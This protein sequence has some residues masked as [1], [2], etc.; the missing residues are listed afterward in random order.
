M[1][2]PR[3]FKNL[4]HYPYPSL[5]VNKYHLQIFQNIQSRK[6][7]PNLLHQISNT[8]HRFHIEHKMSSLSQHP[9]LFSQ[10]LSDAFTDLGLK[11]P[12]DFDWKETEEAH[13]FK[14]DLPGFTREDV[15][16][17]V[18]DHKVLDISAERKSEI[19][20]NEKGEIK[21]HCKERTQ[22]GH[23]HR[24]FRLPDDALVDQISASMRD[25]VLVVMVA[26][27]KRKEK[28]KEKSKVVDIDDRENGSHAKGLGRF[29]C[30]KA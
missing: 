10:F 7:I 8:L 1:E 9:L 11:N 25:G 15:K 20:E 21:W 17:Q 14:F 3:N 29:V 28:K 12:V 24:E 27:D 13:I 23:C 2:Y 4:F 6:K 19:D 26:K 5:L 18:H 30:C 16:L 22:N